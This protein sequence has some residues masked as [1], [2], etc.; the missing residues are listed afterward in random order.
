MKTEETELQNNIHTDDKDIDIVEDFAKQLDK[1]VHIQENNSSE[2]DEEEEL[3]TFGYQALPQE[4]NYQLLDSDDE[5]H[6]YTLEKET[7]IEAP[8]IELEPSERLSSDTTNLI[9]SIMNNIQLSDEAIPDWAKKI[10]EHAW[11]PRV[12]K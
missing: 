7:Y 1:I 2:T 12:K 8:I 11:L 6:S 5:D 3:D 4:D 9:K 10:P